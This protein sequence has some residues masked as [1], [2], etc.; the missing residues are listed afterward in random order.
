M[1]TEKGHKVYDPELVTILACT[2]ATDNFIPKISVFKGKKYVSNFVNAFPNGSLV[3][4][5]DSGL[6]KDPFMTSL[7][8]FQAHKTV[9]C[10]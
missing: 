1:C 10:L 4:M 8:Y 9:A 2:N 3:T 7:P 6:I 5:A